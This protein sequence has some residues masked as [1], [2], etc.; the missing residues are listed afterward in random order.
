MTSILILD[1][2]GCVYFEE[3]SVGVAGVEH[4]SSCSA[5]CFV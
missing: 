4:G 2:T 3:G 5:I 1:V